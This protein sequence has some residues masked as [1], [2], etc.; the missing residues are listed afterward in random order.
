[1][2]KSAFRGSDDACSERS[3]AHSPCTAL[4]A[5]EGPSAEASEGVWWCAAFPFNIPENAYAVVA[6]R[7]VAALL[8]ALGDDRDGKPAKAHAERPVLESAN[9][10]ENR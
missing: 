3:T 2:I 9:L 5:V 7:E 1:M 10:L 8:R 4:A 6:L